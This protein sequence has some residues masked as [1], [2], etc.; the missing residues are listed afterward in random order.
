MKRIENITKKTHALGIVT[1]KPRIAYDNVEYLNPSSISA[2]FIDHVEVDPSAI[3]YQFETPWRGTTPAA[4]DRMDRG[5]LMHI[6]LL[7]PERLATDV[8]RWPAG[9][10][11]ACAEWTEFVAS[12]GNKLII[13]QEDFDQVAAAFN[14]LRF[15]R[16]LT[17]LLADLDAEVA[18]FS[19][20]HG[21]YVKGLIDAVT[22]PRENPAGSVTRKMI[23]IKTTEAGFSERAIE[24]TIRNFHYREKMAAYRRWYMQEDPTKV[25]IECYDVFI[26][27]VPPYGIRVMDFTT[28]AIKWGEQR[29][30]EALDAVSECVRLND[31][32]VFYASNG[33]MVESWETEETEMQPNV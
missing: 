13:C 20:D 33:V 31:W 14:V 12:S 19:Q 21:L 23:D 4:Q 8:A 28:M 7:Q 24:S 3:K 10:R 32:P 2:G 30:D 22:R 18:I 11:R 27:M 26:N 29:I 25:N 16:N 17:E 1:N 5:T 6:M 15:N 9:K